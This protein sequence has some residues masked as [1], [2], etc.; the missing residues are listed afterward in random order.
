MFAIFM[1]ITKL[2]TKNVV[3]DFREDSKGKKYRKN[4]N[5]SIFFSLHRAFLKS[6]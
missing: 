3:S 1:W 6:P 2:S 5:Y 4:N